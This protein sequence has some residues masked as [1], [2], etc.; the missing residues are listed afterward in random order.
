MA[1]AVL[2]ILTSGSGQQGSW[3]F[4]NSTLPFV[5]TEGEP[6]AEYRAILAPAVEKARA[7]LPNYASQQSRYK[8]VAERIAAGSGEEWRPG[9]EQ[10]A[11]QEGRH[12]ARSRRRYRPSASNTRISC[13]ERSPLPSSNMSSRQD[14]A[15]GILGG[16]RANNA[17][18]MKRS[19]R[20]RAG[21]RN[22]DRRLSALG[23]GAPHSDDL[24]DVR[25]RQT[26]PAS[27][28]GRN[29][30]RRTGP[31]PRYQ[32]D[33]A[34]MAAGAGFGRMPRSAPLCLPGAVVVPRGD[35]PVCDFW[36]RRCG[37]ALHAPGGMG[38]TCDYRH[39]AR[40]QWP[41]C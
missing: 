1:F 20:A 33:P 24:A 7:D 37:A 8:K 27:S 21:L 13:C 40:L 41:L 35:L 11:L 34:R 29:I 15:R 28:T 38:R 5:Q 3:L 22:A 10:G 16:A 4:L 18:R 36:R 23:R 32:P 12:P 17:E 6:Y 19:E 30:A 31:R 26:F 2:I 39:R 14:F 9:E 25:G